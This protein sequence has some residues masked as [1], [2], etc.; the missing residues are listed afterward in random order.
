VVNRQFA[1][2][3]RPGCNPGTHQ[4]NVAC[5]FKVTGANAALII[6]TF[7]VLKN[8]NVGNVVSSSGTIYIPSFIKIRQLFKIY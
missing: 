2:D 1:A 4:I 7:F 6:C 8:E 5:G 3:T